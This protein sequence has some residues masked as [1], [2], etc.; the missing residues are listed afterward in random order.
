MRPEVNWRIFH[1]GSQSQAST[2][3]SSLLP[4]LT[5][6]SE[7]FEKRRGKGADTILVNSTEYEKG[8]SVSRDSPESI[9]RT[10]SL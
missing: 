10:P 4:W 7:S 5:A 3:S 9:N 1:E 6:T 8:N 2:W